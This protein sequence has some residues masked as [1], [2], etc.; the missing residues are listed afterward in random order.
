MSCCKH[1]YPANNGNGIGA[2]CIHCVE[3]RHKVVVTDLRRV[4]EQM[5]E[6]FIVVDVYE[7]SDVKREAMES[8]LDAAE[9]C[10]GGK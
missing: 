1:G 7:F 10:L 8:A 6:A 5:R 3:D 9:K 2:G 4:I